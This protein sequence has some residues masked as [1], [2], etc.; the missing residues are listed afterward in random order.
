ME[1]KRRHFS[2]DTRRI[3][4]E[5]WKAKVE[6]WNA[7]VSMKRSDDNSTCQK[8]KLPSSRC[9]RWSN[10]QCLVESMLKRLQDITDREANP[11][12]WSNS[13]CLVES[14]LKRLQDITDREANPPRWS[15]S[16]F[17]VESML[18]RL[19]D[20]SDREA[21]PPRLPRWAVQRMGSFSGPK[22]YQ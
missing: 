3:V 4:V 2:T 18:K 15:N 19:Q 8:R 6:I 7:K 21:N 5:L 9:S 11:P 20:I 17:L 10:S 1:A 13:Q 12:R 14:M 22:L 16:Q